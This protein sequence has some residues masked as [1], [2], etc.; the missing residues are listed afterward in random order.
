MKP[1]EIRFAADAM[2][3]SLAKWLRLLGYD[4]ASGG[5]LHGVPL[6]E[7]ALAEHRWV[8]SRNRRFGAELPELLLFRVNVYLVASEHLPGQLREVTERFSLEPVE[9]RFTRCVVCNEPLRPVAKP[10][11]SRV[12][13]EVLGREDAFWECPRCE[14]Y[15]W[16]GSHVRRSADQVRDW[17][18]GDG[19][20]L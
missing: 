18:E 20:T 19:F 10:N 2:L 11:R 8:L 15:F 14:R 17:L 1:D 5:D 7:F 3:Q 13:E 9:F 4:C 12:P 16:R 6:M